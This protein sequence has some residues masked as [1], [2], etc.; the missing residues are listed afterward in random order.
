ME[1]KRSFGV[2]IFVIITALLFILGPVFTQNTTIHHI[3]FGLFVLAGVVDLVRKSQRKD[4]KKSLKWK[5]ILIGV[6]VL[7]Y[8]LSK[9]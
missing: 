5:L 8:I 9:F 1:N 7:F 3:L 4:E 2:N 6:V